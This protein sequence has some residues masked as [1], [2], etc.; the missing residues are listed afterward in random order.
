[1]RVSAIILSVALAFGGGVGCKKKAT[2]VTPPPPKSQPTS[3]S[4]KSPVNRPTGGPIKTPFVPKKV[5]VTQ[6]RIQ[7]EEGK[8]ILF[9]TNSDVIVEE[10]KT[11]LD[12]ISTVMTENTTI[13]IRV[14]GHTDSDGKDAD[15]LK[16]S[17]KRA[18]SVKAYLESKGITADRVSSE[19]CGEKAPVVK[20]DSDENKAKNRRVEFVILATGQE[21][22]CKVY[23]DAQ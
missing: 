7:L 13:K 12:E 4:F 15:N 11:I 5:K 16:L 14:E 8:V 9:E 22:T 20:N 21:P 10:S 6:E 2:V 3:S 23:S 1:M 19:G 17:Q 18:A